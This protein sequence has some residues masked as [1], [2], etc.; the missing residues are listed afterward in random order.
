MLYHSALFCCLRVVITHPVTLIEGRP[1][2]H[3]TH[4][5]ATSLKRAAQG[6][7][8]HSPRSSKIFSSP[9]KETL[10]LL[11]PSVPR[12]WP[13]RTHLL[14]PN[15]LLLDISYK[16]HHPTQQSPTYLW[17]PFLRF[18]LPVL[19]CGLKII[20]GKFTSLQLTTQALS[21][22]PPSQKAG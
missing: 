22:L 14:S 17:L 5:K 6:H 11:I 16:R 20:N 7:S 9:T 21:H 3:N 13:Q 8:V 1:T 12:P 18:Q 10:S 19:S 15:L 2:Q 4:P